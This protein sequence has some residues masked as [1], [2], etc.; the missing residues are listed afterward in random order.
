MEGNNQ[1]NE[2]TNHLL[3][4]DRKDIAKT[5]V[6]F[7]AAIATILAT[8]SRGEAGEH[9]LQL[10][11]ANSDTPLIIKLG[12]IAFAAGMAYFVIRDLLE[13]SKKHEERMAEYK[14]NREKLMSLPNTAYV[15]YQICYEDPEYLDCYPS[16]ESTAVD[17]KRMLER[18]ESSYD[19][20]R[21]MSLEIQR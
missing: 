5:I 4:I 14:A 17:L 20:V 18:Y 21:L 11:L 12:A 16:G 19:D 3:E 10:Q 15:K 7:S 8:A 13:A 9:E 2:I 6:L 1:L